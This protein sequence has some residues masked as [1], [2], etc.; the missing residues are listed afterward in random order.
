MA[1][2]TRNEGG[3]RLKKSG[4]KYYY[5]G[6]Q[7][8]I[9][10]ENTLFKPY[11]YRKIT[12]SRE[13]GKVTN[14]TRDGKILEGFG[15]LSASRIT[16]YY[17]TGDYLYKTPLII[18]LNDDYDFYVFEKDNKWKKDDSILY[19]NLRETLERQ[20]CK[21]N[22]AHHVNMKRKKFPK[23]YKC[24]TKGCG[25]EI[26]EIFTPYSDY[27]QSLHKISDGSL[28]RFNESIFEQYGLPS[29]EKVK[30]V[31]VFFYPK[32]SGTPFLMYFKSIGKW[33]RRNDNDLTK[34]Y[35]MMDDYKPK[36]DGKDKE[37]LEKLFR[38]IYPKNYN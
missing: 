16:A 7:G 26:E 27:A 13:C 31:Y 17:W 6:A 34:W 9:F 30:E 8:R 37:I 11:P 21:R 22:K 33:Y 29:P 1:G 20:N 35:E 23:K 28:T 4:E 32:G 19:A 5:D 25:V 15:N 12:H 3:N 14:I 10:V 38:K 24:L 18:Q 2:V 36:G